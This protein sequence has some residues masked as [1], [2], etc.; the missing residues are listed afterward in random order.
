MP[1]AGRVEGVGSGGGWLGGPVRIPAELV[2]FN[3][4][5]REVKKHSHEQSEFRNL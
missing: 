5:K 4:R 3:V 1:V 2:I